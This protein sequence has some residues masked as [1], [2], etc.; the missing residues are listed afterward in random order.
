MHIDI[1]TTGGTIDKDYPHKTKGWAFEIGDPAVL[2]ILERWTIPY[3][4][5][6]H[7]LFKKDSLEITNF[8]REEIYKF[9]NKLEVTHIVITHG[10]DTIIDSG[11][12]FKDKKMD[13]T[14]V[15][16]GA[17]RPAK[18]YNTDALLNIGS[19]MSAVQVLPNGVYISINGIVEEIDLIKR[20]PEKGCFVPIG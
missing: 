12:Y 16:T 2:D 5:K 8:D 14:I 6:V 9:I 11:K 15:L 19:A 18:F 20:D 3:S 10:T 17:M 13:K 7:S 4:V 1:I